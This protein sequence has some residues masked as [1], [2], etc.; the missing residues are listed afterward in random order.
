MIARNGASRAHERD[1]LGRCANSSPGL[2]T[3][4]KLCAFTSKH[5]I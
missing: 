3:R 2:I 1:G 5:Y 4:T